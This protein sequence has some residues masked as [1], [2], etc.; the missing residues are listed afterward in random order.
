MMKDGLR[1]G[2]F[3][4]RLR[5]SND[6]GGGLCMNVPYEWMDGCTGY[7]QPLV[8]VYL[9]NLFSMRENEIMEKRNSI[10]TEI[11][12]SFESPLEG[13][14]LFCLVSLRG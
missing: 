7:R 12:R 11:Y 3:V 9:T 2:D 13:C 5:G 4:P 6:F 8:Y 14:D 1:N 10:L